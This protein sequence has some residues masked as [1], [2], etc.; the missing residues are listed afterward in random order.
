MVDLDQYIIDL[1]DADPDIVDKDAVE[2]EDAEGKWI[3][4]ER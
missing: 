2:L 3:R 1:L 4:V